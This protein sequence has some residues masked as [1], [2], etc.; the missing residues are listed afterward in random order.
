ML[1]ENKHVGIAIGA[2]SMKPMRKKPC[3]VVEEGNTAVKVASFNNEGAAVWFMNKF[4]Q[5]MELPEERRTDEQ[6]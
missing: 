6:T 2:M 3:L 4:M 5:F 1:I